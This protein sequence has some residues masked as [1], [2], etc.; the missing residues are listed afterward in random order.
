MGPRDGCGVGAPSDLRVP[1]AIGPRLADLW[2]RCSAA[3]SA[4]APRFQRLLQ[5]QGCDD[6]DAA[7]CEVG[8]MAAIGG[9]ATSS[10]DGS[11]VYTRRA[12]LAVRCL[13]KVEEALLSVADRLGLGRCAR[14]AAEDVGQWAHRITEYSEEHGGLN[15]LYYLVYV[16]SIFVFIV[17][18]DLYLWPS[19]S[20]V[21][22]LSGTA[23]FASG[24]FLLLNSDLIVTSARLAFQASRL[25]Q[26]NVHF[27]KSL[28]ASAGELRRLHKAEQGLQEVE[29]HFRG[30]VQKAV[31]EVDR[32]NDVCRSDIG[33]CTKNLCKL[34]CDKDQDQVI[35]SGPEL[36]GA[37]QLMAIVFG[38]TVADYAAREQRLREALRGKASIRR[39]G[40]IKRSTFERLMECTVLESDVNRIPKV[41]RRILDGQDAQVSQQTRLPSEAKVAG[42]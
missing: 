19:T 3:A 27:Q 29:Q 22:R 16:F 37:L 28:E 18:L 31:R 34:Y 35:S 10:S 24:I 32:L 8:G 42:A 17:G 20:I 1:D 41:A 21:R 4:E 9:R 13:T 33:R 36:D 38:A 15:P 30:D 11:G 25:R 12:A 40:G 2:R 7:D 39:D 26:S 23:L 5:V 6:D 14:T